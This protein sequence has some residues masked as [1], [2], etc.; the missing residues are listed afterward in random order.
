MR[1]VPAAIAVLALCALAG[2]R[3]EPETVLDSDLPQVPGMAPRDTTG[4]RQE[5]GRVTGG[6]FAFKGPVR[7][8]NDRVGETM[9][10]FQGAGWTLSSQTL[11]GATAVLVYRKDTRTARVEIIRNGVQPLMSTA[12][13]KVESSAPAPAASPAPAPAPEKPVS[14]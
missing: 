9:A 2:C 12:V 7:S 10:R 4:L 11:T 14:G 6:Q 1:R 8:L 5:A 13:V 3:S